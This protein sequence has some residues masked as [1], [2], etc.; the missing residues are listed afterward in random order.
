MSD[1]LSHGRRSPSPALFSS[2]ST[3][4]SPSTPSLSDR[5]IA[6]RPIGVYYEH[7]TWFRPLFDAFARRGLSW[8]RICPESPNYDP[9]V[10]GRDRYR[11]VLNRMSPSAWERGRGEAV[12]STGDY[13]SHLEAH[14]V[15]V[16]NGAAAWRLDIDK[17]A[18]IELLEHLGLPAPR[19]RL[20][21]GVEQILQAAEGLEYPLLVKPNNGGN[22]AGIRRFQSRAELA[23]AV[24]AEVFTVGS[25]GRLLVQE[26]HPPTGRSVVRA[27]TLGGR[28]LYAV[29]VHFG[30][31]DGFSLCLADVCSLVGG[32]RLK[33]VQVENQGDVAVERFMPPPEV[34][35][36][37]ER[38]AG[39]AGLDVGGVEYLESERDGRRYYYD[40]NALSNFVAQPVRVLGFDP[41]ERLADHLAGWRGR[42][43]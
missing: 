7:P 38:V 8:E 22:G 18:Q 35:E 42:A 41:H 4:S 24:L 5:S 28:L 21:C 14:G 17:W 20:A 26:Y 2:P 9:A 37:I 25:D 29:R 27:E 32:E 23:E 36:E 13:L 30:D 12:R 43:L 19:T 1:L 6:D 10:D 40:V 34:V 16:L 3:C 31:G 15:A 11:L 39:A 33:T